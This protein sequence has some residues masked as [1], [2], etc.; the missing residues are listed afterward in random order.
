MFGNVKRFHFGEDDVSFKCWNTS[1]DLQGWMLQ[2]KM[3]LD[4]EGFLKLWEYFHERAMERFE[5]VSKSEIPII[6]WQ[7]K[8]VNDFP[9][10]DR[11]KYIVQLW[12]GL[13][14][15]QTKSILEKGYSVILSNYDA[16][17]LDCGFGSWNSDGNNWCTP[18]KS[19][20]T[21]YENKIEDALGDYSEL[22][23]GAEAHLWGQQVDDNT[24]DYKVWPRL[25]A[26]AERLWTN[27]KAHWRTAEPRL[28]MNFK[29]LVENGIGADRLQPDWCLQNEAECP[30]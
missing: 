4:D 8:L 22:A 9:L 3:T 21:I 19:W 12:R 15:P 26:L 6:M 14:E 25:S 10:S 5:K 7:N 30:F 28:L 24:I 20:H 29:R 16:L 13:E 11:K 17:Y 1:V 27:P 23:L 2:Q 18:Y